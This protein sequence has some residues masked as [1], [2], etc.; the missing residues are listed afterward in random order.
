MRS[1]VLGLLGFLFFVSPSLAAAQPDSTL[2]RAVMVGDGVARVETAWTTSARGRRARVT[3]RVGE[4][5][6]LV[7]HEGV[8][9][10]AAVAGDADHLCI[11]LYH[12][13]DTDPFARALLFRREGTTLVLEHTVAI[14]RDLAIADRRPRF[15]AD[16]VVASTPRGFA[17]MVQHQERDPTA[18]V[19]TTL[20]VIGSDGAEVEA[21][22]VVAVPWALADLVHAGDGYELA[23]LWGGWDASMAGSARVCLVHLT[24]EGSPTEHPWWASPAVPL[25]SIELLRTTDGATTVAWTDESGVA[26]GTRWSGRGGW[27]V[28]PPPPVPL[29]RPGGAPW[30][31]LEVDGAPVVMVARP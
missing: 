16:A 18:N 2:L 13:G 11:V 6:E 3:A 21:T 7:V 12:G 1:S 23:V 20:T 31:L 22:H 5:P 4:G 24:A 28:E 30:T 9:V 8:T 10:R 14:P 27:S 19:V 17:V 26:V 15:P 29:G 25:T